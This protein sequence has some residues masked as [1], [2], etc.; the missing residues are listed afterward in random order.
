MLKKVLGAVFATSLMASA[1]SASTVYVEY[2]TGSA[3]GSEGLSKSVTV[4]GST[5]H[6]GEFQL[7]GNNGFGNFAA[8]CV[9]LAQGLANGATY[10]VN[11]SLYGG[12]ILDQIDRLFTSVYASVDTAVEAAGFQVALWEIISDQGGYDL[13]SGTFS[14]TTSASVKATAESYLAGLATADKGGY[15]L[16]FLESG[17]K[18]DIITVTPVPVPASGLLLIAGLGGVAVARRRNKRS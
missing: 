6:A 2:Q 5:F 12:A 7:K 10:T 14:V 4:G 17:T 1:A 16:T 13:N 15:K 18:Q 3:Y 9:D 8:F 11:P